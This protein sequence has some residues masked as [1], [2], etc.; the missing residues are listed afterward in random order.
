VIEHLV[1]FALTCLTFFHHHDYKPLEYFT[2]GNGAKAQQKRERNS[3]TAG[4][5]G[6]SQL[7]S[8]DAAKSIICGT[9]RQTFLVTVRLPQLTEHVENKHSGKTVGDCFPGFAAA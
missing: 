8:N 2:M 6:K 5:G 3:K 1:R 4:G 7:K 9:C